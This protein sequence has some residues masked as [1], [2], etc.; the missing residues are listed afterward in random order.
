MIRLIKS[1]SALICLF[2]FGIANAGTVKIIDY[3]YATAFVVKDNQGKEKTITRPT[4]SKIYFAS[5]L[6]PSMGDSVYAFVDGS[7]IKLLLNSLATP[8]KPCNYVIKVKSNGGVYASKTETGC[9]SGK[10]KPPEAKPDEYQPK[11]HYW[12]GKLVYYDK[13]VYKCLIG[14]FCSGD[15]NKFMPGSGTEWKLAWEVV[16]M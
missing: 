11:H 6:K 7:P 2:S 10:L 9:T 3:K 13:K 4:S 5:S 1:T 14:D 12:G 15:P 8:N 16:K